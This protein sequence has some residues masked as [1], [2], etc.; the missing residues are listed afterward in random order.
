MTLIR[1]PTGLH[2]GLTCVI[3]KEVMPPSSPVEPRSRPHFPHGSSGANVLP[4]RSLAAKLGTWKWTVRLIPNAFNGVWNR[5]LVNTPATRSR[6]R[7]LG[8]CWVSAQTRPGVTSMR[9]QSVENAVTCWCAT[10]ELARSAALFGRIPFRT[11]QAGVNIAG[12]NFPTITTLT[13]LISGSKRMLPAHSEAIGLIFGYV[14]TMYHTERP[15]LNIDSTS[16]LFA[17]GAQHPTVDEAQVRSSQFRNIPSNL[18]VLASRA[19]TSS[20][21]QSGRGETKLHRY[22]AL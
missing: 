11:N 22:P 15:Q 2:S 19:Y 21:S 13:P 6:R 14:A 9:C 12:L 7:T 5:C 18:P 17:A 1:P 10:F 3:V 20:R 4:I 16:R 8:A